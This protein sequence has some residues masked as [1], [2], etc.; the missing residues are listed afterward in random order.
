MGEL[1]TYGMFMIILYGVFIWSYFF[2]EESMLFGRRWTYD[3]E[4]TYSE[5]A[6]RLSK[7]TSLNGILFLTI[8]LQAWIF[9]SNLFT[10]LLFLS[11]F[12]FIVVGVL[13]LLPK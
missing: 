8:L 2:P 7:F 12:V 10:L 3:E 4:P 1:F 11:W 5:T 9:D 6:I 13:K